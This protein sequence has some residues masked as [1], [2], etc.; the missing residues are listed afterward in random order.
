MHKPADTEERDDYLATAYQSLVKVETVI[1]DAEA[2]ERRMAS[3]PVD[4]AR[5]PAMKEAQ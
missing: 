2:G 5:F 1:A 3:V 4:T